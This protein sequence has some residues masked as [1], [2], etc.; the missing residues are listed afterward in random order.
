MSAL[1]LTDSQQCP[2][3]VAFT[4]KKGNP[5]LVEGAPV[6]A[7]SDENVAKVTAAA[8]GMSAV[9]VAGNIGT[10]QISVTADADLGAGVTSL[11]SVLDLTVMAGAAVAAN[12][13]TGAP[14]EQP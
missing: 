12:I 14:E 4:D 6:W 1:T 5:A 8:D 10:A 11:A 13:T 2:V 7:S 9:I 3:S